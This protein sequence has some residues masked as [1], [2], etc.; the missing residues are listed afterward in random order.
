MEIIYDGLYIIR[1]IVEISI[2][3]YGIKALQTYMRRL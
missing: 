1:C 2:M 3:I